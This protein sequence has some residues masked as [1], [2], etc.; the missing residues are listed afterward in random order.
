MQSTIYM[1]SAHPIVF[2]DPPTRVHAGT[3]EGLGMEGVVGGEI[4][5]CEETKCH[6]AAPAPLPPNAGHR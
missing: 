1:L 2:E 5:L 6:Q 4:E 3:K